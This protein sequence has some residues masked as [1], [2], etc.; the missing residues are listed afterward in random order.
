MIGKIWKKIKVRRLV[1]ENRVKID[2][3][4]EARIHFTVKG[5]EEHYVIY[6]K[7]KNEF[8]C[9][10]KWFALKKQECSHILACK[11]YLEK[12]KMNKE[13]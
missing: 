5:S 11:L 12:I 6:D 3:E 9:D 8:S 10:C 13:N 2:F 1:R 7:I 4:T